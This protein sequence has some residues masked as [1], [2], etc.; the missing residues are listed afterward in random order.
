M[1]DCLT[2]TVRHSKERKQHGSLLGKKQLIQHHISK[3][4]VA[5]ESSRWL[6]YRAASARQ[7]LHDYVENMKIEDMD[8]QSKLNRKNLDYSMLRSE[9]D[10]LATIAKFYATN[11]RF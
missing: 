7:K 11:A 3:I 2:E 9:A 10:R 4:A 8:W 1:R 5:V 6:T